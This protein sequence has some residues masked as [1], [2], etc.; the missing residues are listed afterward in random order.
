MIEF[1]KAIYGKTQLKDLDPKRFNQLFPHL[2]TIAEHFGIKLKEAILPAPPPAMS[3][4]N[5]PTPNPAP[6]SYPTR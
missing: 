4:Q 6:G 5:A 2:K 3:Q 1:G